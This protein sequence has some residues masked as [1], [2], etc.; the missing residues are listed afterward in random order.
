M[1]AV[2]EKL[3]PD[4]LVEQN[5]RLVYYL[6]HEFERSFKKY[7]VDLEDIASMGFIGLIKASRTFKPE[8]GYQFATYASMCINNEFRMNL[9]KVKSRHIHGM[10][11]L[12]A[13]VTIGDNDEAPIQIADTSDDMSLQEW[14]SMWQQ[15][16]EI[17]VSIP[18]QRARLFMTHYLEG[19]T[20]KDISIMYNTSQPVVNRAI[21]RE[22]KHFFTFLTNKKGS[23]F[24]GIVQS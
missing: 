3:E 17:P 7:G 1:N 14:Q 21:K 18:R 11:Y 5:M 10:L 9:R 15:F 20:Q 19:M 24:N 23:D 8:K 12:D 4:Q 2:A 22:R 13:T 6:A 16:L